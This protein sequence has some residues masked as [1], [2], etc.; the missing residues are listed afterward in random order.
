MTAP[1]TRPRCAFC[2]R[3]LAQGS[4]DNKRPATPAECATLDRQR[5]AAEREIARLREAS[6]DDL[7]LA[8]L[9]V[10]RLAVRMKRPIVGAQMTAGG[11]QVIERIPVNSFASYGDGLFCRLSCARQ[12]AVAAYRAGFRAFN[13][14]VSR[15][16]P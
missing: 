14:G 9:R 7:P 6:V 8:E 16:K 2:N 3:M 13:K 5:E 11:W 10:A 1:L 15:G 12:F 4:I